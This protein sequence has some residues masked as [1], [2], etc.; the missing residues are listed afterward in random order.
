M[1]GAVWGVWGQSP[2]LPKANG[3]VGAEPP[4]LENF[5]SFCKKNFILG[6]F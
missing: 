1:E 6:L 5:A 4:A 2:Q 3:G